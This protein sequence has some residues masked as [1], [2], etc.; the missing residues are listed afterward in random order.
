[1]LL[2]ERHILLNNQELPCLNCDDSKENDR[3]TTEDPLTLP[4]KKT[5]VVSNNAVNLGISLGLAIGSMLA[6][7]SGQQ[8]SSTL[9]IPNVNQ[10]HPFDLRSLNVQDV[11]NGRS[12][13]LSFEQ[14]ERRLNMLRKC[15][16][17]TM[18]SPTTSPLTEE[19]FISNYYDASKQSKSSFWDQAIDDNDNMT[20]EPKA[21]D[22]ER[23]NAMQE[24]KEDVL[25][26]HNF[27]GASNTGNLSLNFPTASVMKKLLNGNSLTQRMAELEKGGFLKLFNNQFPLSN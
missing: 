7:R 18:A 25:D 26:L 20:L 3:M 16:K 1:M 13:S 2:K 14:E 23:A 10:L 11:Q 27:Q 5:P 4:A 24:E 12:V 9:K 22:N 8:N 17:S 15:S 6:N 19:P 21:F